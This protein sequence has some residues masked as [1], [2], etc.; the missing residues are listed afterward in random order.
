VE[1]HRTYRA[2][3]ARRRAPPRTRSR[4]ALE[5]GAGGGNRSSKRSGSSKKFT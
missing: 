4:S 3:W 2:G 1:E 5:V